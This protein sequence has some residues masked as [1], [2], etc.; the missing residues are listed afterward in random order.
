MQNQSLGLGFASQVTL[1]AS[2]TRQYIDYCI[3]AQ[4]SKSRTTQDHPEVALYCSH[5]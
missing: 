5:Y 1:L 3:K 4:R 2:S